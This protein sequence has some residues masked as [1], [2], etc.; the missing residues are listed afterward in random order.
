MIMEVTNKGENRRLITR[1]TSTIQKNF[2][3]YK[4]FKVMWKIQLMLN[5]QLNMIYLQRVKLQIFAD[6]TNKKLKHELEHTGQQ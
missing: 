1:E 6:Q 4:N 5:K 2:E 3:V